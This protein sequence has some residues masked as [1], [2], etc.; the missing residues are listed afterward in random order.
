[1]RDF[2]PHTA[3]VFTV[4]LFFSICLGADLI[5]RDRP[6]NNID[7]A[8]LHYLSFCMAFTSNDNL[9]ARTASLFMTGDQVFV[10]GRDLKVD[11]ATR[12]DVVR[13][14]PSDGW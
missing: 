5:S 14:L 7:V 6:S 2:A 9:H 13:A 11:F 3:H 4:D 10:H 1:M 8:Y 12:C